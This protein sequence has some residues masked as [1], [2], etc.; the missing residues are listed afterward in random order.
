MKPKILFFLLF[1]IQMLT[2]S[3]AVALQGTIRG[4]VIDA[5][6]RES[7]PGANIQ[8]IG[9]LRGASADAEGR[10]TIDRI[11][12]GVYSVRISMIGFRSQ[13]KEKI[14]VQPD[15]TVELTVALKQ[16]PIEFDPIVVLAGKMQQRLDQA[17]VSLSVVTS[18]ESSAAI[19]WIYRKRW[20]PRPVCISSAAKS[21]SAAPPAL[22]SAPATKCCC[23][24]MAYRFTPAIRVNSIGTCCRPW[25]SNRSRSS[26]ARG[27]LYGG[28]P[29]SAGSS[30]SSPKIRVPRAS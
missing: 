19:P 7:L 16:T 1:L 11:P 29:H 15:R 24:W 5:D 8:I 30:T 6:T 25:M 26:K 14:S 22:R 2:A 4:Q 20:K 27:P 12:P 9:T 21:T 17:P 13:T 18:A 23:S 28:P 3:P 10:F